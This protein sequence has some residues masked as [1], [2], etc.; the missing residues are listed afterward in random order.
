MPRLSFLLI[1]VVLYFSLNLNS[2]KAIPLLAVLL[3]SS[4]ADQTSDG[5]LKAQPAA[6]QRM[7]ILEARADAMKSAQEERQEFLDNLA[8]RMGRISWR[9]ERKDEMKEGDHIAFKKLFDDIKA[10]VLVLQEDQLDLVSYVGNNIHKIDVDDDIKERFIALKDFFEPYRGRSFN[11]L[12]WLEKGSYI[13]N[14]WEADSLMKDLDV[15]QKAQLIKLTKS[16]MQ[17]N[18]YLQASRQTY[19]LLDQLHTMETCK[20]K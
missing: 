9:F 7:N 14:L 4:V 13:Y 10:Y 16:F 17:E 20:S 11:K 5:D 1:F 6:P 15:K 2:Y 19:V 8:V 3:A 12:A 18:G